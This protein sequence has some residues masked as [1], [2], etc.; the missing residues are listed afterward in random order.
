MELAASRRSS[1]R[2][3]PC[4]V[5]AK[6][7]RWRDRNRE[8]GI[9]GVER[10]Q[11]AAIEV[12]ARDGQRRKADAGADV[13]GGVQFEGN[14]VRF[15]FFNESCILDAES[16][17]P[18]RSEPMESASQ[19]ASGPWFRQRGLSAQA[20]ARSFGVGRRNGSSRLGAHRRQSDATMEDSGAT[21]A[22]RKTRSA[23]QR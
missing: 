6:R 13:G 22:L 4:S 2:V 1:S 21:R 3:K 15:Q 17:C 19:M 11:Q 20:G 18:M 7:N 8:G 12:F 9:V 23:L 14:V 10:D 5:C 16:A